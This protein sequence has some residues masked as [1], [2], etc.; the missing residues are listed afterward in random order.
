[1]QSGKGFAGDQKKQKSSIWGKLFYQRY[2]K[3]NIL[4]VACVIRKS[5]PVKI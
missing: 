2:I 4:L 5:V 1:M 3:F